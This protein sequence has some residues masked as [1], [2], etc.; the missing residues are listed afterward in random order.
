MRAHDNPSP[1]PDP[2]LTSHTPPTPTTEDPPT[3]YLPFPLMA[4]DTRTSSDDADEQ[5]VVD[6]L[7]LEP[8][9]PLRRSTR[10]CKSTARY[11]LSPMR[12]NENV[13]TKPKPS[14]SPRKTIT[15]VPSN[16]LYPIQY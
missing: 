3:L 14:G 6:A 9:S 13:P 10:P 4:P 11:E 8:A 1:P 7:E 12:D 15:L 16:A 2:G 5:A